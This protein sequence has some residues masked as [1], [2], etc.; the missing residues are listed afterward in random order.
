M[1]KETF[2]NDFLVEIKATAV[3][4]HSKLLQYSTL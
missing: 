1:F 2:N 3:N 4:P